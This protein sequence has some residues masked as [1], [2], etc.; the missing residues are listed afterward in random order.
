MISQCSTACVEAWQL[1]RSP[2]L[3]MPSPAQLCTLNQP[4]DFLFCGEPPF[5]R[6]VIDHAREMLT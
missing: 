6:E 3:W 4:G 1:H 2:Q 5:G